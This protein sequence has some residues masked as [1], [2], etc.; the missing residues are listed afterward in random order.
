MDMRSD[1]YIHNQEGTPPRNNES[2]ADFQTDN[3]E[4]IDY[5]YGRLKSR[6]EGHILG[7]CGLGKEERATENKMERCAPN[8]IKSKS[9]HF[10]LSR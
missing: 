6:K 7:N 9:N 3:G 5:R 1:T 2:G 4:I 8:Q 10:I